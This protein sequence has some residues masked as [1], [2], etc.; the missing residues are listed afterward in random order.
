MQA[1]IDPT[2]LD[3]ERWLQNAFPVGKVEHGWVMD[4]AYL[5]FR[6]HRA[7]GKRSEI[8]FAETALE[9][10]TS[11]EILDDLADADTAAQLGARTS[12]RFTYG[13]GRA[14]TPIERMVVVCDD[15]SYL[16]VRNLEGCVTV[17]DQTGRPLKNVPAGA[18]LLSSI[19]LRLVSQWREDIQRWR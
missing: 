13:P 10:H 11:A 4:D 3:I 1:T 6:V 8:Q 9:D 7:D 14:I 19:F 16:V 5:L 18:V 12:H 2:I 15:R 17:F